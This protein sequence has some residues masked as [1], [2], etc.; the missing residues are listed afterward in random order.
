MAINI[1]YP[2]S[3]LIGEKVAVV[4]V[5]KS[6]ERGS[7]TVYEC[8]RPDDL[9]NGWDIRLSNQ[10]P[11]ELNKPLDAYIYRV[12]RKN[13]EIHVSADDFGMSELAQTHE[14]RFLEASKYIIKLPDYNNPSA[15]DL[16]HDK[17]LSAREMLR[18]CKRRDEVDWYSVYHL[19]G[20][21]S[22]EVL[23][24]AYDLMEGLR[25]SVRD[26]EDESIG[27]YIINLSDLG[28]FSWY[29]TFV[30]RLEGGKKYRAL[31]NKQL[32]EK[33]Y[34]MSPTEFEYFIADCWKEIGFDTKVV[35]D[36]PD[37][38]DLGTDVKAYREEPWIQKHAIQV[39]RHKPNSTIGLRKVREYG[40]IDK[41][42]DADKGFII[43]TSEFTKNARKAAQSLDVEL[44][45][46]IELTEFI[47]DED[48][49]NIVDQYVK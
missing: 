26:G 7:F 31:P 33:L 6:T 12:S 16:D 14:E 46:G 10:Q 43:T 28:V 40:S 8:E 19:L 37:E 44:V 11:V 34:S 15:D 42:E 45:D 41:M 49:Y 2:R 38:D 29:K 48:L 4:P 39:K 13:N 22:I 9:D 5:K 20:K 25:T 30:E 1:S 17:I 18:F 3:E 23:T 24:D 32:L 47:N 27:G 36:M 35:Q 21:P